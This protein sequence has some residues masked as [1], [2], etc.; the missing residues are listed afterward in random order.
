MNVHS[1]SATSVDGMYS[2]HLAN[3]I[4]IVCDAYERS[5]RSGANPNLIDFLTGFEADVR[6]TLFVELLYLDCELR[7][8]NDEQLTHEFYLSRF[9]EFASAIAN[10]DLSQVSVKPASSRDSIAGCVVRFAHFELL[11]QLGNGSSGIVWKAR[12]T[13]LRRMVALKLPRLQNM[14]EPERARFRREGRACA[15]LLHPNIVVIYQVGDEENCCYISSQLI[16]GWSLRDWL[17]HHGR[18]N[19]VEAVT[20][21]VQL[22]NALQ[23]AHEQGVIHRDL[24]PGN[25]LVD[26]EGKPYLTDFGLARWIDQSVA[27]TMDGHIVGTPAYMSPEQARGD[28]VSVDKRTDIYGLGAILYELLTGQPPFEGEMASVMHRVLNYDPPSPAKVDTKVPLDLETICLKAMEKLPSDRYQSMQALADDLRRFLSGES[29]AAR[30]LGW[31]GWSLRFVRRHKALTALFIACM[32]TVAAL[33]TVAVLAEKNYRLQ[34]FRKVSIATDPPGA[35]I[36]FIP[37]SNETFAPMLD[38]R[39]IPPGFSPIEVDLLPGDY[40][41]VAVMEDGRFHEV[42]RRVPKENDRSHGQTFH[43]SYELVDNKLIRLKPIKIPSKSVD[44]DMIRVQGNDYFPFG[45]KNK[46]KSLPY[47]VMIRPFLIDTHESAQNPSFN[48]AIARAEALGKRLP[49][50]AEYEY[51]ATNGGTTVYP[52]GNRWPSNLRVSAQKESGST[53]APAFDKVTAYPEIVG[54]CSNKAE[55]LIPQFVPAIFDR[56]QRREVTLDLQVFRGGSEATIAGDLRLTPKD[57]SPRFHGEVSDKGEFPGITFRCVR[58]VKPLV[59]FREF[60]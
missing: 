56:M 6:E 18:L 52:W 54:L 21:I 60:D 20:I 5:W 23:H 57:R 58:S 30:R 32:F 4:D 36:A 9:P 19:H 3:H 35:R 10:V 27:L 53:V 15:Q 33:S 31:F 2:F 47:T 51:L 41:V 11:E 13:S 29:I 1:N 38:H 26:H 55:W 42:Y 39:V 16:E 45:K 50:E 43:L 24:K 34:G 48:A 49:T 40:F 25:V 12:D 7:A 8:H 14:T 37:L 28:A 59:S 46:E 44:T 22:A 17:V